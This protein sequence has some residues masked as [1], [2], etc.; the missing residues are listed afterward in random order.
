MLHTQSCINIYIY[1]YVCIICETYFFQV[2]QVPPRLDGC[3]GFPYAKSNFGV[4]PLSDT[5]KYHVCVIS[6]SLL[7]STKFRWISLNRL[8]HN[9]LR[10][11]WWP[12]HADVHYPSKFL[13]I[14]QCLMAESCLKPIFDMD[15]Y[16]NKLINHRCRSTSWPTTWA[17]PWALWQRLPRTGRNSGLVNNQRICCRFGC[18]CWGQWRI[19]K[20]TETEN[21]L[22][23]TKE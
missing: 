20:P 8:T 10:P 13:L 17:G 3:S 23:I 21:T 9:I 16:T 19:T 11:Y 1:V 6:H 15:Q 14:S 7:H 4:Y 12:N 2:S 22:R 18:N 5:L